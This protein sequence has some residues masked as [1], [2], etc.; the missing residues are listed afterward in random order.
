MISNISIVN[1]K[2]LAQIN[3]PLEN[4]T[5][6]T[7]INGMGK[8]TFLQTLLLIRQ[9]YVPNV[10]SR[11]IPLKG[12]LTGNLG[13]FQD[14]LYQNAPKD[15]ISFVLTHY[16]NDYSWSFK[17]NAIID[18]LIGD[19][20]RIIPKDFAL[21]HDSNFQYI[22]AG[23]ITPTSNFTKSG[24]AIAYK[25][26][27]SSGEYAIQY[28]FEKGTD[29]LALFHSVFSEGDPKEPLPLINQVDYWLREITPNVSLNIRPKSSNEFE[30]RYQFNIDKSITTYHAVNSAFG[31]TFVL[32]IIT[33]ILASRPGDLLIFE[34][35]ES[36]LHPRAQSVI[37]KLIAKAAAHGVQIIIET[38]SDHII[39][40]ICL[41]VKEKLITN[42]QIKM[43]Y[44][45]RGHTE[46][47]TSTYEIPIKSGGRLDDS[48]L[49]EKKISGFFDQATND[50]SKIIFE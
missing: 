27:G 46:T 40:G 16:G 47:S 14:V 35:P 45:H 24:E 12:S 44:F 50:L 34:N 48:Y 41:A 2:S 20:P 31:L 19:T 49:R 23:R 3:I 22:S 17:K 1:F 30:L 4:L 36:D 29:E 28:L 37:G 25:Q 7:G 5:V 33:A 38:H 15:E 18:V 26:F 9:A 13:T 10:S 43:Y 39:N 11:G 32:P 42:Q 8:S 21:T 6:I